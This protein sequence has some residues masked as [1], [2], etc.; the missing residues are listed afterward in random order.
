M[1]RPV[2]ERLFDEVLE[3]HDEA[4]LVPDRDHDEGTPDLLDTAPFALD[5]DDVVQADRLRERDLQAREE[6]AED[7]LRREA[8]REAGDA[9]RGKEPGADLAAV[10]GP[11]TSESTRCRVSPDAITTSDAPDGA[12][13]ADAAAA[14][15]YRSAPDRRDTGL[16][17]SRS[18]TFTDI[19]A[20]RA[21]PPPG[22][23]PSTVTRYV[24]IGTGSPAS[25]VPS[26]SNDSDG[27]AVGDV[28]VRTTPSRSLST[29]TCHVNGSDPRAV[30][31][32]DS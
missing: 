27:V 14:V 32:V 5:D 13:S 18:T 8:D 10:S 31:V 15:A 12:V 26:Q 9:R 1:A 28:H 11:A 24:P 30:T 17:R 22:D 19:T 25:F 2:L 20:S 3:R 23:V 6:V 7:G 4:P 21:T 16:S 29:T